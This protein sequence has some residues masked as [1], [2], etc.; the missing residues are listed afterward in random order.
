MIQHFHNLQTP[1]KNID[2]YPGLKDQEQRF[3]QAGWTTATARDLWDLWNDPAVVTKAQRLALNDVECFDEWEEFVLYAS[4][5][6]L[7]IADR[8]PSLRSHEPFPSLRSEAHMNFVGELGDKHLTATFE[9]L[10]TS[11]MRKFGALFH[12]SH[13]S[14][15]YY[16]GLGPQSRTSTTDVFTSS[17]SG[18]TRPPDTANM[19]P[20][21]CHTITATTHGS[22]LAGGRRSPDHALHDCWVLNGNIWSSIGD[23]P[24]PR[25]RH[26]AAEVLLGEAG[27]YSG[28]GVLIYGGKTLGNRVCTEWFLWRSHIG[29]VEVIDIEHDLRPRF[30][31]TMIS[32]DNSMGILLGGMEADGTILDEFWEW[33]LVLDNSLPSIRL[34]KCEVL[35]KHSGQTNSHRWTHETDIVPR[36]GACLVTSPLGFLLVGGITSD[37][38]A[39]DHEIVCLSRTLSENSELNCWHCTSVDYRIGENRPFLVGHSAINLDGSV[40]IVG[41]GAVCFS[42]GTYWNATMMTLSEVGKQMVAPSMEDALSG[43]YTPVKALSDDSKNLFKCAQPSSEQNNARFAVKIC[44]KSPE[45]FKIVLDKRQPVVIGSMYLGLCVSCWSMENLKAKIGHDRPVSLKSH[46]NI[47]T[48]TCIDRRTRSHKGTNELPAKELRVQ[49]EAFQR[50]RR[51][52]HAWLEA[53]LTVSGFRKPF[54]TAR[55]FLGGLPGNGKTISRLVFPVR[56]YFSRLDAHLWSW[57]VNC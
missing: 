27:A 47:S 56:Y 28:S 33:T 38:L 49:E 13:D 14:V 44:V 57:I 45:D 25:F 41:G 52:N 10:P 7:L 54:W 32:T 53:I 1:L 8:S 9:N 31:A 34:K 30:G 20:R 29:W 19:E 4:H 17:K 43:G 23:L 50:L 12:L 24:A 48:L 18:P 6:S 36:I 15:G 16:G 46:D 21:M 42:F 22:I 5:Y 39:Q 55:E 2:S 35:A 26:C 3:R 40:I 11:N 37:I 51:R